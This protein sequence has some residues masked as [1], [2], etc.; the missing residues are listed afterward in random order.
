MKKTT[1]KLI[2]LLVAL[3]LTVGLFSSCALVSVNVDKD[4]EQVIASVQ[5]ENTQAEDI[6]KRD[7]VSGYVSYGYYYVTSYGYTVEA[8]YQLVLDSLLNNKVIVQ[9]ARLKLAEQGKNTFTPDASV[10]NLPA[11]ELRSDYASKKIAYINVLLPFVTDAQVAEA[12]YNAKSTINSTLDAIEELEAEEEKEVEDETFTERTTPTA[13]TV[14]GTPVDEKYAEQKGLAEDVTEEELDDTQLAEYEA[15]QIAK[16]K[17]YPMEATTTTRKAA[18]KDMIKTFAE[19]GLVG[20]EEYSTLE[21]KGLH[22]SLN[23]YTYYVD[24][25]AANLESFVILNYE[26]VLTENAEAGITAEALWDEYVA[27]YNAQKATYIKDLTAYETAL[28]GATED[29]YILYNPTVEGGKYGYV[30]N[31]LIGFSEEITAQLNSF[32]SSATSNAQIEQYRDELLNTLVVTDLRSSWV[33]SGYYE[34]VDK[35]DLSKGYAFGKDYA[36]YLTSF[37]GE[38]EDTTDYTE[39]TEEYGYSFNGTEWAWA[40]SEVEDYKASF[41]NVVP[42]EYT[43]NSFLANIYDATLGTNTVAVADKIYDYEGNVGAMTEEALGKI[44]DLL[45]AFSTDP[46]CL[47]KYLGY[48]YSPK[49]SA[50]TYVKEFADAAKHAVEQGE[51]YY[52]IVATDYGYHIIICTKVV[53]GGDLYTEADFKANLEAK[54]TTAY[55]FKQAKIDANVEKL[56]SDVVTYNISKYIDEEGND[57]AV[58][59]FEKTFKDLINASD[60]AE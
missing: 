14:D 10:L 13:D 52:C 8:A 36:T 3:M 5:V 35:A 55:K 42:T 7:L 53:E 21:K 33:Q 29:S 60:D 41:K 40:E 1:G 12:V 51:G 16:F 19:M 44:E 50:T 34:P 59:K 32:K 45:F 6:Y 23:N 24:L 49:T 15:W 46:G 58:Q 2:S 9:Y 22:L 4:M 37:Y 17:S 27:A 28:D 25:I 26:E 57:Y 43:F 39:V 18:V 31:L 20:S 56:V 38:Y 47:N 48:L 30:A 11:E 54:G